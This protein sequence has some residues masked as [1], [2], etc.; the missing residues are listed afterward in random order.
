MA[1]GVKTLRP[2]DVAEQSDGVCRRPVV[3]YHPD[4]TTYDEMKLCCERCWEPVP[5]YTD[6]PYGYVS[7]ASNS[8]L[9]FGSAEGH[10]AIEARA[11]IVCY[12]C[13]KADALDT[14]GV[15]DDFPHALKE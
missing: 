15:F 6:A 13:Y 7:P 8:K 4:G 2:A 9:H 14:V 3:R 12:D 5:A 10:G 11:K 1:L